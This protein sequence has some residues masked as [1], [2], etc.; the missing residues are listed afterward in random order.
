[1]TNRIALALAILTILSLILDRLVNQGAAT[2]FLARKFIDLV[3][4]LEFWR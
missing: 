1:M 2:V 3:D 4:W